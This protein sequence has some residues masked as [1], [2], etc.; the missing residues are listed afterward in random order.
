MSVVMIALSMCRQLSSMSL[1]STS[2]RI[3]LRRATIW[4][5]ST[6]TATILIKLW[7]VIRYYLVF[8]YL[9]QFMS[10]SLCFVAYKISLPM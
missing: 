6:K 10:I 9:Q 5:Y 7:S 3:V 1:L 2:I 8:G 4:E